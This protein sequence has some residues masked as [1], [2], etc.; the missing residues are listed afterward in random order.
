MRPGS[1]S[2]GI[3]EE[4][5]MPARPSFMNSRRFSVDVTL[6]ISSQRYKIRAA[7]KSWLF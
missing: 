3:E 4:S 1:R 5:P 7:A 2:L 6:R